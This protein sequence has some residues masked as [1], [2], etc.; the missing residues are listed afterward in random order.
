MDWQTAK[1]REQPIQLIHLS[2]KV[3]PM[4]IETKGSSFSPTVILA[5]VL[6][7][8][9]YHGLFP[10]PLSSVML[11]RP[12]C[13]STICGNPQKAKLCDRPYLLSIAQPDVQLL[14]LVLLNSLPL[15]LADAVLLFSIAGF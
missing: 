11:H 3:E 6:S 12:I 2:A 1:D 7:L 8:S 13:E 14:Q 4:Q 15:D 5:I 10:Q 9:L